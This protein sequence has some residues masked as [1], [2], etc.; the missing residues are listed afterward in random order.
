MFSGMFNMVLNMAFSV[1]ATRAM[2]IEQYGILALG[3]TV[4][5]LADQIGMFGL[6][7]YAQKHLSGCLTDDSRLRFGGMIKLNVSIALVL[8]LILM[9]S[10]PAV[11]VQFFDQPRLIPVLR[12]LSI[13]MLFILPFNLI[14]AVLRAQHKALACSALMNLRIFIKLFGLFLLLLIPDT[15]IAVAIGSPLSCFLSLL[16]S[17]IVLRRSGIT[18]SFRGNIYEVLA[19]AGGSTV[20]FAIRS[21]YHLIQDIG[22]LALGKYASAED[23]GIYALTTS[24]A[25]LPS[26]FHS[27]TVTVL[28]PDIAATY[29]QHGCNQALKDNY[30]FANALTMFA[31][32]ASFIVMLT[33]GDL[34]LGLLY[35][36]NDKAYTVF[37]ILATRVMLTF[38]T[39]ATGAFLMMTGHQRTALLNVAGA[40]LL[41]YALSVAGVRTHGIHGVASAALVTTLILNMAQVVEIWKLAGFMPLTRIHLWMFIVVAFSIPFHFMMVRHQAMTAHVM[42]AAMLLLLTSFVFWFAIPPSGRVRIVPRMIMKLKRRA[43]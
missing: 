32:V 35:N 2:G 5:M 18:P 12:I 39:G 25:L 3:M 11:G 42:S 19:V 22:K 16:A 20:V 9:S 24:L 43:I 36:L 8:M 40:V 14:L 4:F 29:R 13:S 7:V 1:I 6:D 10:A 31:G 28:M 17:M 33:F 26:I 23:V 21:G 38:Y 34:A 30:H 41:T 15:L 27:G 37:C